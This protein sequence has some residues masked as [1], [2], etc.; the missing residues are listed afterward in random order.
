VSGSELARALG[1]TP[2]GVS[3]ML[4]RAR[5]EGLTS[6]LVKERPRYWVAPERSQRR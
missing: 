4:E 3:R 5:R 6:Q 2:S 1:V